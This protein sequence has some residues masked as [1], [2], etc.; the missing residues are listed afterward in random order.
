MPKVNFNS[1]I[2]SL[3][4]GNYLNIKKAK[5]KDFY[6]FVMN[7]KVEPPTSLKRRLQKFGVAKEIA[8]NS[9]SLCRRSTKEP[10]LIAFQLK[11]I[12][13][14]VNCASRVNNG[15]FGIQMYVPIVET[16]I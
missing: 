3:K 2:F 7:N 5:S 6:H 11:I 10:Q 14:I 15:K 13:N 4:D 12:H 8:I 9:M 1:Y 16:E